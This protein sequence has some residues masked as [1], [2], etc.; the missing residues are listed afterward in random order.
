MWAL[1][2]HCH[3]L[4]GSFAEAQGSYERSLDFP[5]QPL[6][7]HLVLLRLGSIYLQERKVRH[8]I[9]QALHGSLLKDCDSWFDVM[10]SNR[11]C[12]FLLLSLV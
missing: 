11:H 2:G 7:T 9:C 6:D 3:Y 1:D 5:E 8:N 10:D 12:P 4:C